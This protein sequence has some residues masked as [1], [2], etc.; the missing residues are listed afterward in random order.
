MA[1]MANGNVSPAGAVNGKTVPALKVE[2]L[3]AYYL[4]AYYGIKRE[5][6]AVDDITLTV[7]KDEIYG[8]AGESSCGKSTFIKTIAG[9]IRPPLEVL[10]GT[11]KYDFLDRNLYDLD[12]ATLAD[13]RWSH[14]SCILQGSM[15]V[16]NPVRRVNRSFL[17]SPF[18]IWVWRGANSP[19]RSTSTSIACA[20]RPMC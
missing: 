19:K 9:A 13:I 14:F 7:N 11:I 15:N 4:M 16:L 5:V 12:D 8:L 1:A 17:T 6:R 10:G 18:R 2:K 20:C 3:R